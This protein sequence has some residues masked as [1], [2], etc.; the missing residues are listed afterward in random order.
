TLWHSLPLGVVPPVM[1][2]RAS[3]ADIRTRPNDSVPL[4]RRVR[5]P[6]VVPA[7]RE[8]VQGRA[9]PREPPDE[10]RE[11]SPSLMLVLSRRP[12]QAVSFPGSETTVRVLSVKGNVVRLGIDAPPEVSVLREE[13]RDAPRADRTPP[14]ARQASPPP[15]GLRDRLQ[16]TAI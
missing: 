11:R 9:A 7:S 2:P 4:R 15:H 14:D 1:E 13:L 6:G 5:T 16:E 3:A 10:V 8:P 12:N